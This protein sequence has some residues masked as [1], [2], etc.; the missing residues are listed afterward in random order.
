[1]KFF[2]RLYINAI[3]KKEF[4]AIQV[5][6]YTWRGEEGFAMRQQRGQTQSFV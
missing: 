5:V 1:M 2:R 6:F 4:L 3:L